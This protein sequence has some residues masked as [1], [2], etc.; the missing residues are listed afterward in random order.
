MRA[1]LILL[2]AATMAA[3]ARPDDG[4][5][6]VN[7][8][9]ARLLAPAGGDA[10]SSSAAIVA[11][12]LE[13]AAA[14][15]LPPP[16]SSNDDDDGG[17]F[18]VIIVGAG[19][20]GIAAAL[21]LLRA[22][23]SS[24][25]AAAAA[26]SPPPLRV[27][28]LEGRARP[29]GRLRTSDEIPGLDLGA[30]WIHG[31]RKPDNPLPALTRSLGLRVS[32]LQDYYSGAIFAADGSRA[33]FLPLAT[34]AS[35]WQR[36]F[37]PA[38]AA[39]KARTNAS[40]PGAGDPSIQAV[41]DGWVERDLTPPPPA[42]RGNGTAEESGAL[43]TRAAA[44]L[45]LA[46]N[47]ETLLNADARNLSA[48]RYGDSKTLPADDVVLERGFGALVAAML[49]SAPAP[50]VDVRYGQVV[51]AIEQPPPLREEG[52]SSSGDNATTTVV[53]R[54][55]RGAQEWRARRVIVTVPLGVLKASVPD[56]GLSHSAEGGNRNNNGAPVVST[57][58]WGSERIPPDAA[59][60]VA[61]SPPLPGAKVRAI[62][63]FG[64]GVLEKVVLDYSTINDGKNATS[65]AGAGNLTSL[66]VRRSRASMLPR[67]T[68]PA[69]FWDA[70]RDFISR[71]PPAAGANSSSVSDARF[72]PFSIFLNYYK[73]TGRPVLV[74]LNAGSAA[75]AAA[76]LGDSDAIAAAADAALSQ[77]YPPPAP[78]AA[79][80]AAGGAAPRPPP[81]RYEVTSWATDPLS[82]GSYSYFAVGNEREI[83]T[84]LARPFGRMHFAGEHTSERH[85]ATVHGAL[86]SGEREARLVLEALRGAVG[87]EVVGV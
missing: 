23:N 34:A 12:P 68:P 11:A 30:M 9:G 33:N 8:V 81:Q 51:S 52:S 60:P 76:A 73:T 58:A 13:P 2:L 84:E 39:A 25:A 14:P 26:P 35:A 43:A 27:V 64:F 85:P 82:R 17:P 40:D 16:A 86:L 18:D 19:I 57:A 66:D 32:P 28:V 24:N 83:A 47:V 36:S 80:V 62:R 59:G 38:L 55:K 78:S 79:V 48:A 46:S 75:Q 56:G 20:S 15:S 29:G 21:E 1:A 87:Q 50:G 10:A 71:E 5:A 42:P 70:S 31:A 6:F 49:A 37:L 65:P 3:A 53:V 77:M 74:A 61:F 72:P 45:R 54:T 63:D 41:F 4:E 44:R 7:S 69:V 22:N 67:L